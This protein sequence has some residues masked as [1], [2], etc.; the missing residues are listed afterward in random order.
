MAN[1]PSCAGIDE[2]NT[3]YTD[4]DAWIRIEAAKD[5]AYWD[6]IFPEVVFD[7]A[8]RL[9]QGRTPVPAHFADY[10]YRIQ[11][12]PQACLYLCHLLFEARGRD[13]D[14]PPL[15]EVMCAAVHITAHAA[16]AK[17]HTGFSRL[18][19]RIVRDDS[20][21][22]AVKHLIVLR[23]RSFLAD[24]SLCGETLGAYYELLG[25]RDP[26]VWDD[27]G[28]FLL[29]GSLSGNRHCFP[30]IGPVLEKLS[31]ID[32]G[33][34]HNLMVMELVKYL[35]KFW[36][37]NP[38]KFAEC[39]ERLCGNNLGMLIYDEHE[40]LVLDTI[41]AMLRSGLLD[42]DAVRRLCRTRARFENAARF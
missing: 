26:R 17:K 39:I 6:G 10:L 35:A 15:D 31:G 11:D 20:Y 2:L 24:A 13:A 7:I 12:R 38:E 19:W 27:A 16:L 28:F 29:S 8:R 37:E 9:I 14:A 5:P 30:Q 42:G 21:S 34:R 23:C 1:T 22:Y 3:R 33:G 41:R 36:K 4:S 25:S 32:Y 18:F 40:P